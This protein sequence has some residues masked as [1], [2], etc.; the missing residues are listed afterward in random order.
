MARVVTDAR[1][2]VIH[3]NPNVSGY[4]P[5]QF[6]SGYNLPTT[7]AGK[8]T[9]AIVDAFSQPNILN[10][11]NVYNAQFGLP[12]TKKCKKA[13]QTNCLAIL[14]QNG[15]TS[16]LPPGNTGWGVEISLDVEVAHATCQNCRI[17]L[18]EATTNSFANLETAVNTAAA[19]KRVAA[20]SNSYE[21]SG[22]CATDLAYNHPKIAI[23]VSSGDCGFGIG[24]P[25]ALNT[26]VA[27]GGTSLH[28][29][30][31]GALRRPRPRGPAAAPAARRQLGAVVADGRH[32][33][34]RHRLR[35]GP[36]RRATCRP[37]PTRNGR[38]GLRHVRRRR[39]EQ[40]RR[41]EPVVA[42]DRGRVRPGEQRRQLELPGAE[43]RTSPRAACTT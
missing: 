5:S 39:L 20:I 34:G 32:Q 19:T 6:H 17:N 10:D 24:C 43:R 41:D 2:N 37:T 21:G 11:L 13:K 18:Y 35:V 12:A 27:V 15:A 3:V 9:I 29:T 4:G 23:T 42:A 31:S 16:P 26:V 28:L 8:H 40:C 33:L 38:R 36:R 30:G 22:D 7:V 25:S 1:G 14:N